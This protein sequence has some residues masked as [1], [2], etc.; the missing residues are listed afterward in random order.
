MASVRSP[1]LRRRLPVLIDAV[2]RVDSVRKLGDVILPEPRHVHDLELVLDHHETLA[3]QADTHVAEELRATEATLKLMFDGI[4]CG[5][6]FRY[7]VFNSWPER[8][9]SGPVVDLTQ[10][11]L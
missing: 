9:G 11:H 6:G 7:M 10:H 1:A 8:E 2:R 3:L 4:G 5:S